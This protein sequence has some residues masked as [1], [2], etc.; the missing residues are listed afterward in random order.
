[1]PTAKEI[2]AKRVNSDTIIASLERPYVT[3][4]LGPRR[5]GK[6]T[7]I[8]HYIKKHPD[9]RWVSFNMDIL[10]Q[11]KR[12]AEEHLLTDIETAA[13]Q[14]VGQGQKLWVTIDEVQKCPE[15]FDQIKVI[16]DQFKN[17]IKFIL[18]SSASL[19]LHKLG[20]ESLAGRIE[21]LNLREFTIKEMAM[22]T[23]SMDITNHSLL[24]TMVNHPENLATCIDQVMPYQRVLQEALDFQL[25][26]SGLPEVIALPSKDDRIRYLDQY[27]QSY[28]EKDVQKISDITHLDLYQKLLERLSEHTGSLRDDTRLLES[29]GCARNTL[30]KYRGYLIATKIYKE[31]YPLMNDSV[32][33]IIKSPKGYIRNNGIVS[34]LTGLDSLDL[35]K[36]SSGIGHR[37]ENWFLKELQVWLDRDVKRHRIYFW[38]TVGD[39]EIDFIVEQKPYL[40][41]FEVTYGKKIDNK[42]LNNLVAFMNKTERAKWGVLIYNGDFLYKPD[43]KV[44]CIP[45]WAI[46]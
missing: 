23:H 11:R 26:Y 25:I 32:K 38:R 10:S 9:R 16:Y 3:A 8:A 5:V 13:L 39:R 31:I 35:L 41:P 30:K 20:A 1:M 12:I 44:Y 33:R 42:K 2:Y 22:Y 4:I 36:K 17:K 34:V 37:L 15:L 24:E 19:D 29:L 43:V 18:T 45:A 7:F 14:K 21:L 6:S 46:G 27:I 28:L 40:I